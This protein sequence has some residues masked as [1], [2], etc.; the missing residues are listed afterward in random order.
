MIQAMK[1]VVAGAQEQGGDTEG[2]TVAAVVVAEVE[3][4]EEAMEDGGA[5]VVM[6]VDGNLR[7]PCLFYWN[8]IAQALLVYFVQGKLLLLLLGVGMSANLSV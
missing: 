1:M 4:E 6:E 8:C 2:D 5:V 3:V 7:T